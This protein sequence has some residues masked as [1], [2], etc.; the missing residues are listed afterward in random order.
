MPACDVRSTAKFNVSTPC[1]KP[2][3]FTIFNSRHCLQECYECALAEIHLLLLSF[4]NLVEKP[5]TFVSE[6]WMVIYKMDSL[7]AL[8]DH[9]RQLSD[10]LAC[11]RHWE[12]SK[13][14]MYL[15]VAVYLMCQISI[16][17]RRQQCSNDLLTELHHT[18]DRLHRVESSLEV[19]QK[20]VLQLKEKHDRTKRMVPVIKTGGWRRKKKKRRRSLRSFR[21]EIRSLRKKMKV[22]EKRW[23]VEYIFN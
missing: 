20:T 17:L 11:T 6:N 18:T 21:R 23:V 16:L 19:L 15:S 2:S 12:I 1:Y 10:R 22:F 13:T 7:V 9:S 5:T 3:Q 4:N 8:K 14:I